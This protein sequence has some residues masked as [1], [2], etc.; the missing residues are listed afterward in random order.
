MKLQ[1][2]YCW[3][4]ENNIGEKI[5]LG[6]DLRECVRFSLIPMKE[7]LPAHHF[8]ANE[9]FRLRNRFCSGFKKTNGESYYYHCLVCEGF[10]V[11]INYKDGSII[12]T[13]QDFQLNI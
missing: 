3:E 12:T 2:N 7:G 13:P 5:T 11:Y 10:R 8:I 6:G 9:S 1:E 4:A